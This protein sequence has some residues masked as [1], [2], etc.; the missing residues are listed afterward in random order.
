MAI[1]YPLLSEKAVDLIEKENKLIFVVDK[2]ST[3][4]EI[5]EQIEELYSVKVEDVNTSIDMRG[6]KKAFVKL[7]KANSAAELATKLNIL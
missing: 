6:K 7:A 2:S 3:K 5:K 4:Q 1:R